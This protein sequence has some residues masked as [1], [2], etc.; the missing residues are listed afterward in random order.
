[1]KHHLALEVFTGPH[2]KQTCK[3]Y[4]AR[5]TGHSYRGFEREFVDN[6]IDFRF[7]NG[8]GSRGCRRFYILREN[9]LYEVA[10]P[11]NWRRYQRYYLVYESGNKNILSVPEAIQWLK[12]N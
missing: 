2:A 9:V 12:N 4:V 10:E 5:I 7:A 11:I 6:D 1:M 8:I 3:A